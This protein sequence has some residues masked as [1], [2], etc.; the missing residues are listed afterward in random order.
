[1]LV[2]GLLRVR[3]IDVGGIIL[4]CRAVDGDGRVSVRLSH[5]DADLGGNTIDGVQDKLYPV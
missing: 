3:W 1:M 4:V 2:E 5:D